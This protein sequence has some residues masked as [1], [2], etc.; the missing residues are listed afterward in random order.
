MPD[1]IDELGHL[2]LG[3]R[4]KRIA[5]RLQADAAKIHHDAGVDAQPAEVA[6]LAALERFGPMTI[7]ALVGALGVSQPGVTR[8]AGGLVERGL[9]AATTDGDDKRQRSLKLTARGKTLIAKAKTSAWPLIDEAVG[10]LC[11]PLEGTLLEQLGQLERH[12]SERPLEARAAA[13]AARAHDALAI[14]E[15]EDELAADFYAINEEWISS[16]FT[17]EEKDR[18][19]LEHPRETIVDPG[20]AIFFVE[21]AELG[22]VGTCALMKVAPGVFELTKMG[23]RPSARGRKA[24]E[25]LLSTALARAN[26]MGIET[27]YL[28]TNTKCVA[29]IRLYE[30]FG[31]R[32]DAEIMRAYGAAYAR[33][34]VAMRY[35][36]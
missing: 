16:M 7:S 25:L 15:Y 24:G 29:A 18:A 36:P 35:G 28:L 33:S 6:L 5:E 31:F 19:I 32:H 13:I 22:V 14:R 12:L 3:S 1:L 10:A 27:L 30:K 34:D 2:F 26:A 11:A 21:S 17:L 8:T 9:V 4:L 20:G 23:V